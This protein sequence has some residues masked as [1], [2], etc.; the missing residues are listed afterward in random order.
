MMKTRMK[1]LTE[2]MMKAMIGQKKCVRDPA[3]STF[4]H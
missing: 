2:T 4:F 3:G 1:P